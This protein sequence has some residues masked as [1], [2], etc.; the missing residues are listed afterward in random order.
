MSKVDEPNLIELFESEIDILLNKAHRSGLNYWQI[1]KVL[2]NKC[3]TLMMM[4]ESEYNSK[5]G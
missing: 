5:G 1:F 2:L 4:S 3:L